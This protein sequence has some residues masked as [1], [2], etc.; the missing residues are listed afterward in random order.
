MKKTAYP[1]YDVMEQKE[2]WDE[3]TRQ[4]VSARNVREHSYRFLTAVEAE[5]LRA[6]CPLL[7]DDTRG[8]IIQYVLCHIDESLDTAP[9]EGQRKVG[10][11][12]ER[13]LLRGGLHA[14]EQAALALHGRNFFHLDEQVRK[15]MV[16]DLS[17]GF[18]G[19][20][21]VWLGVPQKELFS[22]VLTMTVESYYSHPIVWS[23]IGY[24]GPAYPR[25][26]VRA[27]IGRLDP[28]EAKAKP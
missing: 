21:T 6:W 14:L 27:D 11:P 20:S 10:V 13:E 18:A 23:E 3:H 16:T 9:G 1:D 26:Y 2:H 22:K 28:W 15:G 25:G 4:I 19:P 17:S 8:E 24:G 5:T 7:V 12:A